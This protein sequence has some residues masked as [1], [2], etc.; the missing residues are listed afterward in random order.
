VEENE[1]NK[2]LDDMRMDK[3]PGSELQRPDGFETG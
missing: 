2:E 1:A 3:E